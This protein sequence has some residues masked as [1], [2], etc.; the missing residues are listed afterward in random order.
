VEGRF[1]LTDSG[2][3]QAVLDAGGE[4]DED[5]LIVAR[6]VTAVGRS[7]AYLGGAQVPAP[8]CARVTEALI[9]IH[10]QS[11]QVRLTAADRQR[12]LLDRFAGESV[13]SVLEPYARFYA[14][15]RAA[16]TELEK[17]RA[18]AQSRAREIDVLRFGLTEIEQV[19]PE[20]GE[21]ISLAAEA[22]RLHS[23]DDLRIA[24]GSALTNIAGA[25]DESG[26]AL[27]E[28]TATGRDGI[29][30]G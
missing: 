14:E 3:V 30:A 26:G 22:A 19:A 4:L 29:F 2:L 12:T 21:D 25:D 24:A 13:A 9:A 8:V 20:A 27:S 16:A 6:Q 10:G 7:R 23:A 1:Q 28:I 5:E 15:R 18:E 11:E 17:L